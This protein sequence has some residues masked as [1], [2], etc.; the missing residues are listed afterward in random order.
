M[1]LATIGIYG[2]MSY[3][4]AQ[5]THEIGVRMAVGAEARDILRLVLSHGMGLVLVGSVLGLIMAFAS[6]RVLRSLL[7]GVS[8]TDP[9]TFAGIALLLALVALLA[10]YLPA[11]RAAALNPMIALARN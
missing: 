11:R 5:R 1:L 6:T 9:T 2:V 7:F 3:V 4:V 8:A 10:C